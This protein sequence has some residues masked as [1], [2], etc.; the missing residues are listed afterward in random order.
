MAVLAIVEHFDVL[1]DR[2]LRL[3][4]GLIGMPVL[5]FTLERTKERLYGSIVKAV[6]FATH[7]DT[8]PLYWLLSLS[9][10]KH[11]WRTTFFDWSRLQL[12]EGIYVQ[13]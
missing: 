10:L 3:P 1:K 6:S 13:F 9:V 4:T 8:D 7:A 5:P 12:S 2:Q 11:E